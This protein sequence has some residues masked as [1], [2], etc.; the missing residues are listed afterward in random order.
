MGDFLLSDVSQKNEHV[1]AIGHIRFRFL[2][3]T[4][5]KEAL[6]FDSHI[7]RDHILRGPRRSAGQTEEFQEANEETPPRAGK[8]LVRKHYHQVQFTSN[9]E[10]TSTTCK[11][12]MTSK[13]LMKSSPIS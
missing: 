6:I 4:E 5:A 3:L 11:H 12:Q 2:V 7:H 10:Q 13:M 9:D 1:Y 8:K